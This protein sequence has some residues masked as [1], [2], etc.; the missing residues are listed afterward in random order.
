VACQVKATRRGLNWLNVIHDLRT[1]SKGAGGSVVEGI[2]EASAVLLAGG[3]SRRLGGG[4]KAFLPCCGGYLVEPALATCQK[5]FSQ[6]IVVTRTPEHY[7]GYPVTAVTDLV[8]G[9]G[10]LAGLYTGLKVSAYD[11]SFVVACDMPFLN[12]GFIARMAQEMRDEDDALLPRTNAHVEQL[13]AFYSR[14]CLQPIRRALHEGRYRLIIFHDDVCIRFIPADVAREFDPGLKM[15][16]NINRPHD[17]QEYCDGDW[18][19]L[20]AV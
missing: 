8:E 17:L 16:A 3:K 10:P 11:K 2:K 14:S 20:L 7:R 13:H 6:V 4:D 9:G 15:F 5:L 1:S 19:D 12:R 18:S